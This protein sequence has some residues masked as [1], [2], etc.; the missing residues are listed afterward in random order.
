[1]TT[2]LDYNG[3]Y[4]IIKY[5][6][7]KVKAERDN[8]IN[9]IEKKRREQMDK[10]ADLYNNPNLKNLSKFGMDIVTLNNDNIKKKEKDDPTLY[11]YNSRNYI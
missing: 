1:M 3:L 9:D 6:Y 8:K 2:K 5:Q 11:L 4:N 7:D 10:V